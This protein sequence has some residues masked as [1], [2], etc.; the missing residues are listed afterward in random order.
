MGEQPFKLMAKITSNETSNEILQKF[1]VARATLSREVKENPKDK[2]SLEIG[3]SKSDDFMPQAKVM[4]WDNEV[5]LSVR[6]AKTFNNPSVVTEAEKVKY[7]DADEEV[8]IYEK[9]E[10]GEDGGLEIE[11]LVKT[12][13]DSNRFAFSIQTKGLAFYHQPE[14]TDEEAEAGRFDK[15]DT[16]T[17][18]E[19]KRALRPEN[20]VNSIA[21]YHASVPKNVEGGTE[22]KSGKFC[23]IY[24]PHITDNLGNET[25]GELDLD[26]A[27]GLLNVV[28]PQ[29]FIDA[30]DFAGGG[31]LLIDPTF[32]YTSIGATTASPAFGKTFYSSAVTTEAGNV[33]KITMYINWNF[34]GTGTFPMAFYSQSGGNP[35]TRLAL[36]ADVTI[37]N[38]FSWND[39]TLTY[40]VAG[41]TTYYMASQAPSAR[42]QFR[43]DTGSSGISD[44]DT[45]YTT[46][47]ATASPAAR[48]QIVSILSTLPIQR[49]P[50]M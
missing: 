9:P 32:G 29:D 1:E 18:L 17:T 35:N 5:N 46:S 24:R 33:S 2:I 25:W 47:P 42:Y 7:I 40:T 20:V 10:V 12:R 36:G 19:I 37:P 6:R 41:S 4:R 23:H 11:L 30:I 26:E 28:V 14:L 21:V 8:H 16:R 31:W 3:D 45:T 49:Q 38:G 34:S 43:Y 44:T 15:K 27:G 50:L 48:K 39:S 22:Y 13:P